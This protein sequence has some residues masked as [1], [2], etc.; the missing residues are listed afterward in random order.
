MISVSSAAL[1]GLFKKISAFFIKRV[2]SEAITS[3]ITYVIPKQTLIK[4][5]IFGKSFEVT[6]HTLTKIL[7][8]E[9][10][11][12]TIPFKTELSSIERNY[13][14]VTHTELSNYNLTSLFNLPRSFNINIGIDY[15]RFPKP[16]IRRF[17][18]FNFDIPSRF[19]KP[20]IKKFDISMITPKR[21]NKSKK[22]WE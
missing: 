3:T 20:L 5:V 15:R 10:V 2:I 7:V 16:L 19:P 18:S 9:L 13:T 11:N 12:R 22:K 1:I 6:T 14:W 21:W 17:G 8:N 4:G